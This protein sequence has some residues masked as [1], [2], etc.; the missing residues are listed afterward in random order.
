MSKEHDDKG[1]GNISSGGWS[2][3]NNDGK[4]YWTDDDK[5]D[6]CEHMGRHKNTY[7]MGIEKKDDHK[8]SKDN[9]NGEE[10]KDERNIDSNN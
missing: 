8:E 2:T 5:C 10:G 3:N 6:G 1:V 9:D 4:D 7:S